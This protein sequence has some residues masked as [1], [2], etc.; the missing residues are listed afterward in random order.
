MKKWK[1]HWKELLPHEKRF[2][3]A[4]WVLFC[5][6]VIFFALDLLGAF[7]VLTIGFDAFAI[8]RVL[9]VA[10]EVCQAVVYW[11]TNRNLAHSYLVMAFI[12]GL[13]I[14]RAIV[15]LFI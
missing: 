1:D 4:T 8:A 13:G 11:R 15:K 12:F 9:F 7:G 5:A 6:F 2:E 3:V 14:L 10:V